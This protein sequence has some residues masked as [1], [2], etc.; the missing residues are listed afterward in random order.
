M[1]RPYAP[2]IH[3]NPDDPPDYYVSYV[4][5]LRATADH[6]LGFFQDSL[7]NGLSHYDGNDAG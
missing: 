4:I 1:M 7:E 2:Y 5:A 3:L 6:C